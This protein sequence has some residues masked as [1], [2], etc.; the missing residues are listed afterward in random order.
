M[1]DLLY[2]DDLILHRHA[3][4]TEG[5]FDVSINQRTQDLSII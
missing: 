4:F 2:T 1:W 5:E 3:A